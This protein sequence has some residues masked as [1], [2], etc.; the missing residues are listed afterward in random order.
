MIAI[1]PAGTF[2]APKPQKHAAN[3]VQRKFS[4]QKKARTFM[5]EMQLEG[6]KCSYW[7]KSAREHIVTI[8]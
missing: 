8:E 2:S 5:Q 6:E 1:G 3:Y 4:T 7:H